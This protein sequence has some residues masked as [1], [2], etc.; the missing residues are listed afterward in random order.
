LAVLRARVRCALAGL[1]SGP[2]T[3]T[4]RSE[5]SVDAF[6][7]RAHARRSSAGTR[8]RSQFVERFF[9]FF[10]SPVGS[11]ALIL[12][13][14]STPGVPP[15]LTFFVFLCVATSPRDPDS[16]LGLRK[17]KAGSSELFHVF[18]GTAVPGCVLS[19]L[20]LSFSRRPNA[21]A[22]GLRALA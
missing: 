7:G 18:T 14:G 16:P 17:R 3:T 11:S 15:P 4:R 1:A 6:H 20:F 8:R 12:L 5:F 9:F 22:D 10:F 13:N 21:A 19:E 2:S